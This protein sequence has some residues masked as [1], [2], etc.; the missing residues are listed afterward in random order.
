MKVLFIHHGVILG[1]APLSLLYLVRELERLPDMEVEIVCHSPRMCDYFSKNVK[2]RVNLWVDPHTYLGKL[3]IGWIGWSVLL[4][5]PGAFGKFLSDLFSMPVSVWRQLRLLRKRKPRF[6]HLN[7][8]T[9]F[10]S[11]IAARL[12]G[13]PIIWHIR[14]P[15]QGADLQKRVIGR[16]IHGMATAVIAISEEEAVRLGE[17]HERKVH[18]IY[19]PIN[20]DAMKPERYNQVQE[21]RRLGFDAAD[22]LVLSLGGVNPRKGTLQLVEAMQYVDQQTYLI[23]AGP[24]LTRDPELGSYEC[25]VMNA[26]N[27][28]PKNKVTFT[29][30]LENVVP[31]LAAC[32]VLVFAGMKPHFPRPAY[33]A[34]QM[35]K[36]VIVFEM[37]GVSSQVEHGVDGTI[38]KELS[39]KALGIAIADLVGDPPS[40]A[41]FGQAGK[42]KAERICNP[43]AIASQVLIVYRNALDQTNLMTG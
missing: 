43:A 34:W 35:C 2:S 11:A 9:L 36:P 4:Q 18:V 20:T 39:S 10:S 16:F 42:R 14:E 28:L 6:V 13:I 17:D 19:N 25:Q 24:S 37:K 38:V 27:R 5:V 33:E 32:D 29:G 3:L 30:N 41:Q 1:G 31:L 40:M 12:A 26:L 8:A 15:L 23:I 22:K 21:K 7:S